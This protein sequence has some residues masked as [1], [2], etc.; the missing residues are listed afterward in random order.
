MNRPQLK[1]LLL[2]ST[3][4]SLAGMSLVTVAPAMAQESPQAAEDNDVVVVTGTRIAREGY[5]S[6]S[7][8]T[9]ID[10]D[11]LSLKQP[12]DVE[13]VLR[14]M[15]QFLPGN[16]GQ[17]NNGSSGT[18]TLDLR[19]LS[20]PR[21]LPLIDGKRMVAFDPNGLFDVTAIPL[22]LL[23]RVDVVTGGA[24]A[25]Y[26][27]DAVAGVV[28]FILNDDFQGAQLDTTYSITDHG[29]G[30]TENIQGTVGAGFEDGRGNVVLSIGY[31]NKEAVYQTRGPGS[32]TPGN[33]FT[34]TPTATDA[35]GPIGDAQ[36][37]DNGDLV[38]FYQGF[39]FNP[40]NL[41]QSPQKRWNA[42][43]L[44]KY[45]FNDDIEAYSRFIY[46]AST[47]SPQ[48]AS[49]GTF[50]FSFEVPLTNPFLSTQAS[51][52]FAAN[53][54]VA[55]CSNAAAGSCVNV[56]LYWRGVAVG[57]RQYTFQYDTFQ[58]LVGLRGDFFGWDW[59]IAAAHGETSLQRQ[60]NNDIDADKV[61]QAL[62]ASSPTT[63]FDPANGCA[64]L[65]LF[66][67]STPINSAA[68]DFI[69]LNLQVQSL[70]TQDYVTGSI[71]R[72]LGDFKS[73]MA[74]SPVA[75]SLGFEVRGESADYRPDAASQS[76]AS[77]G[78][79][80]TLP[81][82]GRYDVDEYF[83]EAIIPVIE[84]APF[85]D[86][87]NVELGYRTSDYSTSG[88]VES[89]KYGA[90]WAPVQDLR[91]RTMFQRAVRAANIAELFN[92]FNAGTG[93]LLVDPCANGAPATPITGQL[94]DL[95]VATGVPAAAIDG[96]TITQ[97]TS[98]Q[99]NAFF[100]GDPNVTPEEAD[101]V[102]LGFVWQ[103]SFV[104]GLAVTLDYYDITVDNAISIR[105]NYDIVDA[106][107]SV[108]RN[109]TMSAADADCAIITRNP[110]S[111]KIQG[112]L[113]Y[114]IEQITQNIGEVHAEGI[115]YSVRYAW[116]L[117]QWGGL[118]AALDGTYVMDSS[119]L[120]SADAPRVDCVGHYG[121]QCGLPSTVSGSTG[122]PTPEH[123]FVQRTTWTFG[124]FDV[125]YL[126]RYLD[127]STVDPT[128][129]ADT[130]AESASIP[131]YNYI[132]LAA[133]WQITD[134]AKLKFG[135][136]NVTDEEAPFVE[137]ETGSTPYNS[138]NTYPSTYD[139]LGRVFTFGVTTKF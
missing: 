132:D 37:G 136:T 114:G 56:P 38:P 65:N 11:E 42:T 60:Q 17:V 138:G 16:G 128:Q 95:C 47:S 118:E 40:Q 91:F 2:S 85:A 75:V 3:L 68:L 100:G 44:A 13:E 93:D 123:R 35:P 98:G 69:R 34:T 24:S 39:D 28:N 83:A 22:A 124:D 76:G 59:D 29:D 66:L 67:P 7:P 108:A 52:Y 72:D 90:D 130:P 63:C 86:S 82:R 61:Q 30:E 77:P 23:E 33:S 71:S 125:S 1:P 109:P 137:T 21:T 43:A 94:R 53:N 121:K 110:T 80:P 64:P 12:I 55:A 129:A 26:G 31:A 120:P 139:V 8:I 57:P 97:P 20:T 96:G 116:D 119:Y 45:A 105:P 54:P 115:D 103:P 92:P 102:T 135:V 48:L 41:Y 50:G 4:L 112:D 126:W 25:V 133:S 113:I 36:F 6:S 74:T 117:G 27:S 99:V 104:P 46:S 70:T 84:N 127:G 10:A 15:P 89:Y 18:S 78:F 88:K 131:A 14:S 81:T 106:C 73:P 134:W 9:T 87:L 5:V 79:G 107:Y 101:T 32:A 19:G 58:G 51:N 122:G 111:G 49:S 62:F